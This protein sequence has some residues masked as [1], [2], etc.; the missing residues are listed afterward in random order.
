M[1]KTNIPLIS[2]TNIA[3]WEI[4]QEKQ[5]LILSVCLTP[6]PVIKGT[7]TTVASLNE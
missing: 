5:I 3:V 6:Y 4:Y 7:I 1:E 2:I